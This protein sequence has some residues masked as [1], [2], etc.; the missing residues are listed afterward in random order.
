MKHR[1][2]H[3]CRDMFS[4]WCRSPAKP[5]GG[6]QAARAGAV[7]TYQAIPQ[8]MAAVASAPTWTARAATALGHQLAAW[9]NDRSA[10]WRGHRL[11]LIHI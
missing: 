11:S 6:K 3:C 2:A 10:W 1:Q 4:A 8:R 7:A 5:C 9:C